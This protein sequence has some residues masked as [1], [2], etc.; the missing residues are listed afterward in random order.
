MTTRSH[1]WR[2][3]HPKQL[4]AIGGLIAVFA[5]GGSGHTSKAYGA[6]TLPR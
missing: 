4:V 1:T 2:P 3:R 6:D 5:L